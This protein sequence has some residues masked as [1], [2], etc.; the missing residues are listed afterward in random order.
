M[1]DAHIATPGVQGCRTD[2]FLG[3]FDGHNGHV[4]AKHSSQELFKFV[5]STPAWAAGDYVTALSEGYL[6]LDAATMAVPELRNEGGCTAVTVLLRAG[7]IYCANAGD[8]RAVLYRDGNAI[9]LSRDHKPSD[10]QEEERIVKA[11]GTIS[12]KRVNGVL[13]LARAIGDYEFKEDPERALAD[14]VITALPDVTSLDA[15]IGDQFIVLACDGVWDVLSN[16]ECC[17]LIVEGLA[18]YQNDVGLVCEEVLD[19]CLAPTAP[20]LGCDNMT[21]IILQPKQLYFSTLA[22]S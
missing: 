9:P 18:K 14:Q 22:Q 6:M 15:S 16:E 5:T 17:A 10:P 8:S 7:K 21:I 12:N 3:V 11:G 1:E 2:A 4:I 20:A 19:K 13:S